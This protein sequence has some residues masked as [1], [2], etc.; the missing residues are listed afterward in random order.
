[1]DEEGIQLY[2]HTAANATENDGNHDDDDSSSCSSHGSLNAASSQRGLLMTAEQEEEEEEEASSSSFSCHHWTTRQHVMVAMQIAPIWFLANWSYNAS[3]A[4]TS[5][6]SSTVLASTGSVFT[7]IFAVWTGDETFNSYK[8]A[9]V[10]LGVTGCLVTALHDA[11]SSSSSLPNDANTNANDDNNNNLSLFGDCLGLV[12]A[13]GYG[14]Y[15]VQTRVLCPHQED[16]YSMELL[17]GFIGLINAIALSPLALYSYYYLQHHNNDGSNNNNNNTLTWLVLGCLV[18]K[19]L[20]DNALSDYLWLRAV[21]LTSATVATVGLGLTIPLA[22]LSDLYLSFTGSSSV[23]S[24]TSIV[25]AV[26]VLMGFVLV[27]VGMNQENNNNNQNASTTQ[28]HNHVLVGEVDSGNDNND[29]NE[30]LGFVD[31]HHDS[32]AASDLILE[33]GHR[34]DMPGSQQ[35]RSDIL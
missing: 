16:L 20:L 14:M 2:P 30:P 12:S 29:D 32:D 21:I 8:L 9:G 25:G 1:M 6:T 24:L 10:L 11:S 19:G 23:L 4:Y 15:A 27:N 35:T 7:F 5:I 22:F 18:L 31:N 28:G 34:K 17:L 13:I 3:L 26:A 33:E